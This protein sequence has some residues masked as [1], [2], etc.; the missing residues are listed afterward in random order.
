[1]GQYISTFA[2][3]KLTNVWQE[4]TTRSNG[5]LKQIVQTAF[6]N[7]KLLN[8]YI[9]PCP[10]TSCQILHD[11]M[12]SCF[13]KSRWEKAMLANTKP[14]KWKKEEIERWLRGERDQI[15][16]TDVKFERW[17]V[18]GFGKGRRR[19]DVS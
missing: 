11:K 15:Q 7:T 6:E 5:L 1:M 3:V 13:G 19:P 4:E 18:L 14:Q 9:A 17:Q 2:G 12:T 8:M 16:F 10:K